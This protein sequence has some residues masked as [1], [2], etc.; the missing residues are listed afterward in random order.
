MTKYV[1]DTDILSGLMKRSQPPRLIEKL[2]KL[3]AQFQ[4]TSAVTIG[5]LYYGAFRVPESHVI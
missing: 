4:F 3:P 1:F 2:G 5:E